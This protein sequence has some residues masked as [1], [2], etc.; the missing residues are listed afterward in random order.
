VVC[1]IYRQRPLVFVQIVVERTLRRRL[2]TIRKITRPNAWLFG[3]GWL[4]E[5]NQIP[6]HP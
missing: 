4:L 5:T 6:C 3:G 1:R 2:Q